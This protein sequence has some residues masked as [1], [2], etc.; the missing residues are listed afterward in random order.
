MKIKKAKKG[1]LI[2]LQFKI[3][4]SKGFIARFICYKDMSNANKLYYLLS[5]SYK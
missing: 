5:N 1:S 3:I 4:K 2:H